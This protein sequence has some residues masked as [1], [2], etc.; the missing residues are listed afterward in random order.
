MGGKFSTRL[1]N[2][3]NMLKKQH[4]VKEKF[5][6]YTTKKVVQK[7]RRTSLFSLYKK[8]RGRRR[9]AKQNITNKFQRF[10]PTNIKNHRIP[11]LDSIRYTRDIRYYSVSRRFFVS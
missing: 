2:V 6:K 5:K 3:T 4:H 10:R 9:D 7:E 11:D 8:K 1:L